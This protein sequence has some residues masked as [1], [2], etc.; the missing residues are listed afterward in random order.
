MRS[1]GAYE[2]NAVFLT[3]PKPQSLVYMDLIALRKP[4]SNSINT[5]NLLTNQIVKKIINRLITMRACVASLTPTRNT[6][7]VK[8]MAAN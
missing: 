8:N 3:M 6:I 7:F 4:A 5:G 1:F 2:S